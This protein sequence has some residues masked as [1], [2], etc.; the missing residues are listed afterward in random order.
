MNKREILDNVKYYLREKG[1]AETSIQGYSFGLADFLNYLEKNKYDFE[2]FLNQNIVNYKNS[3]SC[4]QQ[5]INVRLFAIRKYCE[6][7]KSQKNIFIDFDVP[8]VKNPHKRSVN[9]ITE[10]DKILQNIQLIQKDEVVVLRDKLIFIFLYYLGLRAAD[11]V[12]IKKEDINENYLSLGEKKLVLNSFCSINLKNYINRVD[13][14]DN[15]YIFFSFSRIYKKNQLNK[16]LTVKSIEDLFNKYTK[17]LDSSYSINDLRNSY[18]INNQKTIEIND[19]F[20]HQEINW[21]GDYLSFLFKNPEK[22]NRSES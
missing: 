4:S 17:F 18:R 8:F 3:L 7:L 14:R 10:F 9:V 6:Y 5:T 21:S 20:N 11:L 19:A 1:F 2:N 16:G 22:S 13:L 12:K 15:D